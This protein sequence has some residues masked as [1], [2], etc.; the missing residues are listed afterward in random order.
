M[1]LK[2]KHIILGITGSIAAYKAAVLTRL[3]IKEGAQVKIIVTPH[4]KEF[5]TPVTLATLSKNTV[6]CDFF[7]H[8]DGTW[9]SHIELGLWAD[10]MLIAPASANTI[11]KMAHGIADNLLLT[12]YLSVRC[13]VMVAPAMDTDM[14]L[15]TATQN[16]IEILK[17]RDVSFIEP[18]SGELASG[19]I[20]KGRM[21]E[22]E[23]ILEHVVRFF[24]KK[25]SFVGKNILITAGPTHEYIDP[26]RYIGNAS[27]G[28]MGYALASAFANS[29]AK[30]VLVSGPVNEQI[31]HPNVTVIPVVSAQEMLNQCNI[32]FEKS[33]I[34]ILAAAVA[35]FTPVKKENQKIKEKN[36]HF[37][38]ELQPTPDIGEHLGKIKSKNQLLIGF[39]LET[40]DFEKNAEAKLKRKNFDAIILNTITSKHNPLGNDKNEI[41]IIN[42]QNKKTYIAFKSKKELASDIL[43]Y[44]EKMNE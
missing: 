25:K 9:N 27:S 37:T 23:N 22:P 33:D 20:G 6:L 36:Q 16:N 24:N 43:T 13:P 44:I 34:V 3:L 41:T 40:H 39:A 35:D 14:Y 28:K 12:T 42:K 26:V 15:H 18:P 2:D 17:H 29:G 30:V 7:H 5:I 21:E 31:N 1:L 38:L 10:L 19:L 32:F 8:D 4:A 11:A